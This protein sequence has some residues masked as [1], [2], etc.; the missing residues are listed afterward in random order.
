MRVAVF[1]ATGGIGRLVVERLRLEG[2]DVVAYIRN[3]ATLASDPP[4][5]EVVVG[6][7]SER[8]QVTRAVRGA[9]AVISALGPSLRLGSRGTPVA[10]GTRAIVSAMA[11]VGVRRYV[12]LATT[13]IPDVRD[14]RTVRARATP[15][16]ARL[17]FPNAVTELVGM[18]A[19]VTGADLDWTVARITNPT[20]QPARGTLRVGFLGRDQVGWSMSRADIAAFLVGQLGDRAY[21]GSAP[22]ISN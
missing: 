7:L 18:S 1:G 4:R 12:G 21:V 16:V 13:S 15:L 22:V 9:D 14:R 10:D 20:N 17:V 8:S 6:Q 11:D 19:A 5:L 3:P 2:H